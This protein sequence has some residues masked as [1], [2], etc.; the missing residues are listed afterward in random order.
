MKA[1][2]V[3]DSKFP[4]E[5]FEAMRTAGDDE[6][7]TA[8]TR[9]RGDVQKHVSDIATKYLIPGETQTPAMMFVPSELIYA[10]L[11]TS[12][13]DLVQKARQQMS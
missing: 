1:V 11:H 4:L 9:L 3:V 2:V 7:K 8:A 6:R 5:A 13:S 10:E 12:F